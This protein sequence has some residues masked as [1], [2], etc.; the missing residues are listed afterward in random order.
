MGILRGREEFIPVTCAVLKDG[1]RDAFFS[2]IRKNRAGS[3]EELAR[4]LDVPVALVND[5]ISGKTHM[6]F[7][8]LQNIAYQFSIELP[9]ISELRRESLPAAHLPSAKP[10]EAPPPPP[11]PRGGRSREREREERPPRRAKP[12]QRRGDGGERREPVAHKPQPAPAPKEHRKG[13]PQP[14]WPKLSEPLAYWIGVLYAAVRVEGDRLE[15]SADRRVG[16][17]FA[18]AWSRRTKELFG[19]EPRLE[20]KE[21]GKVQQAV[22]EIAGLSDFIARTCPGA[23]SQASEASLPRWVWSNPA[24][25]L[26]C[27]RGLADVSARFTRHPAIAFGVPANL[28]RSLQK[29]LGSAGFKFEADRDG[30]PMIGGR[31]ELERYFESVGTD[32]LKLRDQWSA[33]CR[34]EKEAPE[35]DETEPSAPSSEAQPV[36]SSAPVADPQTQT[37]ERTPEAEPT[38]PTGS[39][40]EAAPSAEP[41]QRKPAHPQPKKRPGRPRRTLYRGRPGQ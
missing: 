19:V 22:C 2:Q 18:A 39:E 34:N 10:P 3:P 31:P 26:A 4:W 27:L 11:A 9:P 5:W 35:S 15:L 30:A 28:V 20:T 6:P 40:G 7:H 21:G 25:K 14:R 33:F 36:E 24:W 17:N 8:T 13:P 1:D 38:Q 37:A 16:Q 41:E 29:L 12:S 32:N 23:G